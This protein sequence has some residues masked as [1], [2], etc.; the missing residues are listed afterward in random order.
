MSSEM[1]TSPRANAG[2]AREEAPDTRQ[3][4]WPDENLAKDI[5]RVGV[6]AVFVY[7]LGLIL[8]TVGLG[9]PT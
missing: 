5:S 2:S 6:A 7:I 9:V 1:S 3:S 8:L 4:D